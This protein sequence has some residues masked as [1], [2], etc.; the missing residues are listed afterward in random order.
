MGEIRLVWLNMHIVAV[1]DGHVMIGACRMACKLSRHIFEK[2]CQTRCKGDETQILQ[3]IC[4]CLV[5]TLTLDK[6]LRRQAQAR[7]VKRYCSC[8]INFRNTT[9]TTNFTTSL[10]KSQK[11]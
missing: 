9:P 1:L 4:R 7:R 8:A 11:S 2:W 10:R 6:N 3:V 5:M